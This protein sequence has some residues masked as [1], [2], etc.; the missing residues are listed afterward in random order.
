MLLDMESGEDLTNMKVALVGV[1]QVIVT[2]KYYGPTSSVHYE[3]LETSVWV[4][5]RGQ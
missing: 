3:S 2:L 1:A 4:N 5:Y